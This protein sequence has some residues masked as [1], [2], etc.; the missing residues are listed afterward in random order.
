MW[1]GIPYLLRAKELF[2]VNCVERARVVKC[3]WRLLESEHTA[4][5]Y[6]MKGECVDGFIVHGSVIIA[7][8][9]LRSLIAY[10]QMVQKKRWWLTV[11]VHLIFN[12]K[13]SK[14]DGKLWQ[15]T[16]IMHFQFDSCFC[17][18][19]DHSLQKLMILDVHLKVHFGE[20]TYSFFCWWEFIYV[21]SIWS[22]SQQAV[23]LA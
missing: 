23:S 16:W 13:K 20:Q 15:Q 19:N 12:V 11:C 4:D 8:L 2:G 14:V 3:V 7:Q 22:W 5:S 17:F 21:C 9:Q 18:N 6:H 10:R 1:K